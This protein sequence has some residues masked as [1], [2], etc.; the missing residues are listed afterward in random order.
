MQSARVTARLLERLSRILHNSSTGAGLN[1][2]QWEALRFFSTANRFSRTP[3]G[4]TSFLGTTKGTVSQTI[5]T[6]ENKGLL[7]K[8]RVEGDARAVRVGLTAKGREALLSDPLQD[9]LDGVAGL[10]DQ[11]VRG[12]EQA[13]QKLLLA[14]LERRGGTAFGV[15]NTCT[16]FERHVPEGEPHRCGLL[17]VPLS[18]AD[19]GLICRE[20]HAVAQI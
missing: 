14:M 16:Y 4:L 18:E 17:K 20:H 6:L 19:S 3:S 13:L 12:L 15:C 2:V 9:L 5:N 11:D 7:E 10:D 8:R 1:P